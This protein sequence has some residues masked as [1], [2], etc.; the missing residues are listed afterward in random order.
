MTTGYGRTATLVV[1]ASQ[2]EPGPIP[3]ANP[4][5]SSAA[6]YGSADYQ[7][8]GTNDMDMIYQA[9]NALPPA[10]GRIVLTE[11]YFYR[12][13]P[14]AIDR[15]YVTIEGQGDSTVIVCGTGE[16][17]A[18]G[19]AHIIIGSNGLYQDFDNVQG[20]T[21]YSPGVNSPQISP[22]EWNV[23]NEVYLRNFMIQ[24]YAADDEA[25]AGSTCGIINRGSTTRIQNVT[26]KIVA[27]DGFRY[28]A[29]RVMTDSDWT[30]SSGGNDAPLWS[31]TS[32]ETWTVSAS[33]AT[34]SFYA[35]IQP[36]TG[37]DYD[38]EIVYVTGTSGTSWTVS[39][40]WGQTTIKA[41][42]ANSKIYLLTPETNYNNVTETCYL[43]SPLRSGIMVEGLVEDSE[44][45]TCLIAGGDAFDLLYTPYGIYSAGANTRFIDC[46]PWFCSE[47]G[48]IGGF[49][50]SYGNP[51]SATTNI[52][53]GEYET[54]GTAGIYAEYMSGFTVTGGTALYSSADY[55]VQL[56]NVNNFRIGDNWFYS[57]VTNDEQ[58]LGSVTNNVLIT[59]CNQGTVHDN[60]M[61]GNTT[62]PLILV[63]GI[64][65]DSPYAEISIHD[66][67]CAIGESN[68]PV[69][70][71]LENVSNGGVIVHDNICEGNIAESGTSNYS[72]IHDNILINS[73]Y[74]T[75]ALTG[76]NS[77]HRNNYAG[78]KAAY[79][80]ATPSNPAGT[81]STSLVMCGIG[82]FYTPVASGLVLVNCTGQC[83]LSASGA[84]NEVI[85]RYGPNG[86]TTVA[87]GSNGGEISA[88]ASWGAGHGGNGVL[89]VASTA[90][91]A[92]SGQLLVAASGSTTAVVNYTGVSGSSFTGCTYVSGSATGT[93]ST[94]GAVV[95][96]PAMPANG[97]AVT[98]T[99]WGAGATPT[100]K[101]TGSTSPTAPFAFTDLLT[102]TPGVEYWFDLAQATTS[103][104]ETASLQD[105]KLVVVEL[106]G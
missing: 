26:V 40:G 79:T 96:S 24:D 42:P 105:I 83:A 84:N 25:T 22:T 34:G 103:G 44:W 59:S 5:G 20:L 31:P 90:G 77:V 48:F 8:N 92:T 98:G 76:A 53:G 82:Q 86:S 47:Y 91:F 12:Q 35:I 100:V 16:Y 6:S 37:Y 101:G 4:N 45:L 9:I 52:I 27:L 89:D 71:S 58:N 68:Q 102:L 73:N 28:E 74:D 97:N 63:D 67:V 41:H 70:I 64:G 65:P 7:C 54:C 46:H 61:T 11:G 75:V 33:G 1:A 99:I 17:E 55:N 15:S 49:Q 57:P 62:G 36:A 94:G 56:S 2:Y 80:V 93:V 95:A 87:S 14:L 81:T 23:P 106:P 19:P 78:V 72:Y 88:I 104:A 85:G 30:L 43:Y 51:P 69:V 18:V 21:G 29:F 50:S 39:R 66:N 32:T 60:V 3:P 10:G 38:P 13:H